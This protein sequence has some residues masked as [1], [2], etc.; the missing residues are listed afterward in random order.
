MIDHAILPNQVAD[1]AERLERTEQPIAEI[2]GRAWEAYQ[3]TERHGLAF[4]LAC[5]ECQLRVATRGGVG[6]KGKG[7]V[8]TLEQLN[9]P[10]STAYYWIK[11]YK[12]SAGLEAPPPEPEDRDLDGTEYRDLTTIT[13]ILANAEP[14]MSLDPV[15]MN[16][17]QINASPLHCSICGEVPVN[18]SPYNPCT[19][20][21]CGLSI[22]ERCWPHH[23][24]G[25]PSGLNLYRVRSELASATLTTD[26]LVRQ[27]EHALINALTLWPR[28]KS[29]RELR[30][31]IEAI[32]DSTRRQRKEE[33]VES[34]AVT[35]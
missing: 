5:Y 27:V 31:A 26:Q 2:I 1:E 22:C 28:E 14:T 10:K 19:C 9:I 21:A 30:E 13:E 29:L 4:G 11:R 6:N 15:A 7:I 8:P 20:A 33:V 34:R 24:A 25:H 16:I 18:P 17:A 12:W 32:L 35:Q 3:Q 23:Q